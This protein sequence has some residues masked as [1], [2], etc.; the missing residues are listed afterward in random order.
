M[1]GYLLRTFA[2][3]NLIQKNETGITDENG[4][5]LF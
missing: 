4:E 5:I 1:S 3:A 2:A